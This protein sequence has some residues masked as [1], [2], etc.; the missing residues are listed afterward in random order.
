MAQVS[1][2][3]IKANACK[4]N[5]QRQNNAPLETTLLRNIAIK[6]Y[7][8]SE[9][10]WSTMVFVLRNVKWAWAIVPLVGGVTHAARWK[11]QPP[12]AL[13]GCAMFQIY[14]VWEVVLVPKTHMFTR[15]SRVVPNVQIQWVMYCWLPRIERLE[16]Q[17]H[18]H[19]IE[20]LQLLVGPFNF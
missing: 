3:Q 19:G 1:M 14:K 12:R 11:V 17:S 5:N 8:I 10:F 4:R 7:T 6:Y 13:S 15:S 20:V 16:E 2:D 18:G 9:W